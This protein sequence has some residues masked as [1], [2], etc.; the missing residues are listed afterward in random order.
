MK[1]AASSFLLGFGKCFVLGTDKNPPATA[2]STDKSMSLTV[3]HYLIVSGGGEKIFAGC[4][5]GWPFAYP[6]L[7]T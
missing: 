2:G 5:L 7:T 4:D 6:A 1:V 3:G